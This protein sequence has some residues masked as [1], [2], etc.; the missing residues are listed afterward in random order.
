MEEYE[1]LHAQ[2]LGVSLPAPTSSHYMSWHMR[3]QGATYSWT[4][5]PSMLKLTARTFQGNKKTCQRHKGPEGWVQL[6]KV[7]YWVVSQLQTQILIKFIFRISTK[8]QLLSKTSA[9]PINLKFKILT[10]HSFRISTKMKTHNLNQASAER[11]W[12]NFSFKI[13]PEF[14]A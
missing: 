14:Q 3:Y 12:P 4:Y 2:C 11:Y 1:R 13:S 6:T 8:H 7:T 10:K 9:S 5:W